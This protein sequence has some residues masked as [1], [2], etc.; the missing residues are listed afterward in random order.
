M[1]L[2]SPKLCLFLSAMSLIPRKC[3]LFVFTLRRQATIPASESFTAQGRY[4]VPGVKCTWYEVLSRHSPA[5]F[6]R[7]RQGIL[8]AFDRLTTLLSQYLHL[9]IP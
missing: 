7:S 1:L 8:G 9:E 6:L 3:Q 2:L 5:S 4:Q